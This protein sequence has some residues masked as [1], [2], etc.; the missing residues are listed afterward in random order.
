MITD[1]CLS[2]MGPK[3]SDKIPKS[4]DNAM[5]KANSSKTGEQMGISLRNGPLEEMEIDEPIGATSKKNGA[6]RKA[7]ESMTNGKNYKEASSEN[8]EDNEPLVWQACP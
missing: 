1:D 6:K 5:D 4:L 7:R 2:G 8:E 3:S